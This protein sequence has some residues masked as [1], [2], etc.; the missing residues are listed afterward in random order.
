[1]GTALGK[2]A[3]RARELMDAASFGPDALKAIGQAFDLAWAEI[4]NNFGDDPNDVEKARLRLARALLSIA[5]EDSR[6]VEVLRRAALQ[7]MA[8]DYKRRTT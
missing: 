3:A 2:D 6:D 4:A 7:R 5:H 8:L 1:M